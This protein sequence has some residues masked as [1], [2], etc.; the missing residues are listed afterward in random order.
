MKSQKKNTF[1]DQADA[2][3]QPLAESTTDCCRLVK[4]HGSTLIVDCYCSNAQTYVELIPLLVLVFS[5]Y[6]AV[7]GYSFVVG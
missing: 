7:Q 2:E 1:V 4:V 5:G 6:S 3:R